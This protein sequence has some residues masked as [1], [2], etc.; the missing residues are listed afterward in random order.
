MVRKLP[1]LDRSVINCNDNGVFLLKET[2]R[3]NA[4]KIKITE[5]F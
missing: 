2:Q 3:A 4:E 5:I 1:A